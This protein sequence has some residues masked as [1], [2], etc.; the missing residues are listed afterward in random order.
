MAY[1]KRT[2]VDVSAGQNVSKSLAKNETQNTVNINNIVSRDASTDQTQTT[3][4]SDVLPPGTVQY[5]SVFPIISQDMNSA[6]VLKKIIYAINNAFISNKV[7]GNILAY[8]D[9]KDILETITGHTV[10]ITLGPDDTG[11][12]SACCAKVFNIP[13]RFMKHLS[14]SLESVSRK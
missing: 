13:Q 4:P 14:K 6:Q 5:P 10:T 3:T 8:E 11:G 12:C 2:T 7:T 9:L 1:R